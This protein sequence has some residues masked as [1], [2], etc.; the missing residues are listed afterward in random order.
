VAPYTSAPVQAAIE[1]F[2]GAPSDLFDS[3][4]TRPSTRPHAGTC[5]ACYGAPPILDSEG[6]LRS[7][8]PPGHD[9]HA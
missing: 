2:L 7:F 1:G 8:L 3:T 5:A 4:P 6:A 9:G